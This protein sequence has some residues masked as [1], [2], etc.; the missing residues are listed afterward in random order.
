[1]I[2]PGRSARRLL[3]LRRPVRTLA[4]VLKALLL[5]GCN[6]TSIRDAL[7]AEP[8]P[9]AT[10]APTPA[11]VVEAG[12]ELVMPGLERRWMQP[13]GL[14]P[15]ASVVVHRFDPANFA[16]R[17]H[18][19][20]GAPLYNTGWRERYPDAVAFVNANFFDVSNAALGLVVADGAYYG[21]SYIN[22]GGMFAVQDGVPRVQ[23]LVN[24]PYDGAP[25]EQAVQGFPALI[26]DRVPNYQRGPGDRTSRRTV[27]AQDGRGRILWISTSLLGMTLDQTAQFLTRP[28]LDIVHALNLDGGGSTLL[29]IAGAT[30][31]SLDPVPVI[32][33][34]YPK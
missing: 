11:P 28:D 2:V 15:L 13:E 16:F 24:Y 31:P 12:W 21:Q 17:A 14:G 30:I 27:V 4:A 1:V 20:P 7:P 6:L 22:R 33:A 3:R 32:L 34:V 29:D 18:I 26:A 23:P 25:L 9:T 5:V 10:P 19:S 8:P